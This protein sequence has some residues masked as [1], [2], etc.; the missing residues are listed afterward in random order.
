MGKIPLKCFTFFPIKIVSES[1]KTFSFIFLH[2]N[3][4]NSM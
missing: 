3:I 2:M 4:K 1:V